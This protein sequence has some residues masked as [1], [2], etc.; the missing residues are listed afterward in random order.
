[1]KTESLQKAEQAL[2]KIASAQLLLEAIDDVDFSEVISHLC[3]A[4]DLISELIEPKP[5]HD[6]VLEGLGPD[7]LRAFMEQMIDKNK[8]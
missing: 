2:N 5:E 4:Y 6:N 1:M 3:Q 8:E 7:L